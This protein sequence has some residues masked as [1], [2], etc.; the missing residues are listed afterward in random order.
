M[1]SHVVRVDAG[2]AAPIGVEKGEEMVSAVTPSPGQMP[3]PRTESC[4]CRRHIV[5][6]PHTLVTMHY[7]RLPMAMIFLGGDAQKILGRRERRQ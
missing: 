4:G 2:A 1:S 3:R 5:V 7:G 6:H